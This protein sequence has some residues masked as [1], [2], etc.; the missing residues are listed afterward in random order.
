M[1]L[2]SSFVRSF[3]MYVFKVSCILSFV[4]YLVML[5]FVPYGL[6]RYVCIC[7]FVFL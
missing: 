6:F 7:S 4:L 5:V 2:F 3:F 1:Y